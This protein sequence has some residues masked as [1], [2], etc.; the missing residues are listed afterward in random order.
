MT[1]AISTHARQGRDLRLAVIDWFAAAGEPAEPGQIQIPEPPF[2]AVQSALHWIITS[3][4]EYQ[5]LR[6]ARAARTEEEIDDLYAAAD[7]VLRGIT[8]PAM[9]ID[10]V[11]SAL[12]SGTDVPAGAVRTG[13]AVRE[14]WTHLIAATGRGWDED[15]A[16]LLAE[17]VVNI[18]MARSADPA[19]WQQLVGRMRNL[20]VGRT[21]EF[22]ERLITNYD[23]VEQLR[24]ANHEWLLRAR[25]AARNLAGIG[26]L[27]LMHALLM[28]DIPGM[29]AVRE[30]AANWGIQP[31]AL[32]AAR[33]DSTTGFAFLVI[34][35]LHPF[36]QAVCQAVMALAHSQPLWPSDRESV[37]QFNA[38]WITAIQA[39]GLRA[40]SL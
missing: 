22:A 20:P 11:R 30:A 31:E 17:A 10:I 12:A 21:R 28:P 29:A 8:S 18:G 2:A 15:D 25:E 33:V 26:S 19:Q 3:S 4:D 24:L 38:D 32:A 1:A 13:A 9:D 27:L 16:E 39:A 37:E 40:R 5:L 14:G 7:V 35:C 6:R 36:R 34:G 23:P